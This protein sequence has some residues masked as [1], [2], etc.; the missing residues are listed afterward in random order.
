[1]KAKLNSI[2]LIFLEKQLVSV[3]YVK[4][5]DEDEENSDF[6]KHLKPASP[7]SNLNGK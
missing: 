2:D 7:Q 3:E 4:N 6:S 5:P 1:M